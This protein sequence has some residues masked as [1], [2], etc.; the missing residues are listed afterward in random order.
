MQGNSDISFTT[1]CVISAI[2]PYDHYPSLTVPLS[3]LFSHPIHYHLLA[4][5]QLVMIISLVVPVSSPWAVATSLIILLQFISY[6]SCTFMNVIIKEMVNSLEVLNSGQ[7]LFH[8]LLKWHMWIISLE[9]VI[10]VCTVFLSYRWVHCD[11]YIFAFGWRNSYIMFLTLHL[12]FK[13]LILP[14]YNPRSQA[15]LIMF[16]SEKC[17]MVISIVKLSVESKNLSLICIRF[18]T[19]SCNLCLINPQSPGKEELQLTLI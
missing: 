1:S 18:M 2:H 4:C 3:K 17:L 13:I 11:N 9:L 19:C 14:R 15:L 10:S 8:L 12:F 16:L 7:I 5:P 6:T